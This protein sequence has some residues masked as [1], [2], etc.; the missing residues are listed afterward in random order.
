MFSAGARQTYKPADNL[1]LSRRVPV[2]FLFY[3]LISIL[4]MIMDGVSDCFEIRK[5]TTQQGVDFVVFNQQ[6]V[7]FV[8]SEMMWTE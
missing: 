2:T 1:P 4:M 5:Q 6:D 7:D 3:F 8:V